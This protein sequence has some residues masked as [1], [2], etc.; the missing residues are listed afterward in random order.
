MLG[1]DIG[2]SAVKVLELSRHNHGYRIEACGVEPVAPGAIQDKGVQDVAAVAGAI[3]R[4]VGSSGSRLRQV[5]AAVGGGTAMTKM[6]TMPAGL[7]DLEMEEQIALEASQSISYPLDEVNLDF[8]VLGPTAAGDRVEVLLAASRS[9]HVDNHALAVE[10]AGLDLRVL[11]IEAY[12]L[13]NAFPLY[14]PQLPERGEGKH[15]AV[16]DI[17]HSV[18]TVNVLQDAQGLYQQSQGF[19]C[20]LLMDSLRQ[21]AGMEAAEALVHLRQASLDNTLRDT[22][23]L[24]FRDSVVRHVH[25]VV[26]LFQSSP[27]AAAL[28]HILLSGGGALLPEVAEAVTRQTGIPATTLELLRPLDFSQHVNRVALQR[29]APTLLVALGL[30]M[31]GVEA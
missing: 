4:A 19:G 12:A 6:I 5:V 23:L 9:D 29:Q 21:E 17:G 10:M 8:E 14:A 27:Q 28:D 25:R 18:T 15:V 16:V 7:N 13:E 26:Q 2:S 30:A 11:D 31:R 20:G 3:R 1:L 24:P 22:I